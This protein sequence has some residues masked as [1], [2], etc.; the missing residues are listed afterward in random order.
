MSSKHAPAERSSSAQVKNQYSEILNVDFINSIFD[1]LPYIAAVL[2]DQRQVIFSNQAL[3]KSLGVNSIHDVLGARPG[4]MLNCVNS[5]KEEGG[6][7]T[8]EECRYCGAVNSILRSQETNEKVESECTIVS[9][10]D[11]GTETYEFGIVVNPF[12]A[13][14]KQYYIMSLFDISDS[15]RRLFL[16]KIFFHD[17]L[18]KVGS[19]NG[20]L[21]LIQSVSDPSKLDEYIKTLDVISQQLI[22]EIFSQKQLLEAENGTLEVN[23][24][25]INSKDFALTLVNQIAQHKVAKDISFELSELA[26]SVSFFSDSSLLGR[27]IFN[28]LKNAAE[29]SEKGHTIIVNCIKVENGVIFSVNNP[30]F[31]TDEVKSSIFKRSFSTKGSGRGLGTYSM[32]VLTEKYLKG[33]IYFESNKKEGTTFFVELNN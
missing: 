5:Q 9:E 7:G 12:K 4:E 16:E 21:Q 11:N 30:T 2:N 10:N 22:S 18:N 27:V 31:M 25:L 1:S 33:N 15:K 26:D 28:M 20:F 8:S 19:L 23:K 29:A 14:D 24:E 6:C 32:K 13:F 17:I 3:L